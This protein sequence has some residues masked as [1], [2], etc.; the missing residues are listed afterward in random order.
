MNTDITGTIRK[1]Q[2]EQIDQL[3]QA[4]TKLAQDSQ[5]YKTTVEV[6]TK[7]INQLEERQ[8]KLYKQLARKEIKLRPIT[9]AELESEEQNEND[10]SKP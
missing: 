1:R 5:A 3:E 7:K 4:I 10:N 2:Q 9:E 6:L 8:M